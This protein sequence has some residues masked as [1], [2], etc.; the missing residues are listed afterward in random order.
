ML[1]IMTSQDNTDIF[2]YIQMNYFY[3]ASAECQCY[4]TS[5]AKSLDLFHRRA[6]RRKR[7]EIIK[8]KH[9]TGHFYVVA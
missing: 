9:V 8:K 7:N 6:V 4:R 5:S 2:K 1:G 3:K